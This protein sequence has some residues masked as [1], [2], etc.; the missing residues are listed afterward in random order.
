LLSADQMGSDLPENMIDRLSPTTKACGPTIPVQ[1]SS[2]CCGIYRNPHEGTRWP[3]P[4]FSILIWDQS[5]IVAR[6]LQGDKCL[7]QRIGNEIIFGWLA[8]HLWTP[9]TLTSWFEAGPR[10]CW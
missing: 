2:S 6:L 4:H 8:L 9:M 7:S 3:G 5:L 10:G 1:T